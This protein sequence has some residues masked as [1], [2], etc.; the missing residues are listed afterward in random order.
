MA[1]LEAHAIETQLER[2]ASQLSV[3]ES[4]CLLLYNEG[5]ELK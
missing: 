2:R 3:S 4:K 1:K 5:Q